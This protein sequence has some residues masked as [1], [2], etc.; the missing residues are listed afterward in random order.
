METDDGRRGGANERVAAM[1]KGADRRA[2]RSAFR[3]SAA[4][5]FHKWYDYGRATAASPEHAF[6]SDAGTLYN[7]LKHMN[8]L[9][10]VLQHGTGEL[11]RENLSLVLD[12]LISD[13]ASTLSFWQHAIKGAPNG[14]GL[15]TWIMNFAGNIFFK[16]DGHG[17]VDKQYGQK[18]NAGYGGGK[19][20]ATSIVEKYQNPNFYKKPSDPL[21]P[22]LGVADMRNF[23]EQAIMY[24]T[25]QMR[26]AKG[27]IISEPTKI[28][29]PMLATELTDVGGEAS[30]K[31]DAFQKLS[32]SQF[33]QTSQSHGA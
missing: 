5:R 2:P 18:Y 19:D 9:F 33:R 31:V 22:W 3:C 12:V 29:W 14:I 7:S 28:P 1:L 27:T 17:S 4:E 13:V 16:T 26:D 25:A 10:E 30:S 6:D 32:E 21:L 11:K 24:M 23:S 20:F 15:I 8:M